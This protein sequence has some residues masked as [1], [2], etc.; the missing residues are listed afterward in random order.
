MKKK[1]ILAIIIILIIFIAKG[2]GEKPKVSDPVFNYK[3]T[4]IDKEVKI[5]IN[6]KTEGAD[7]YYTTDPNEE[8]NVLC[9]QFKEGDSIPLEYDQEMTIRAFAIKKG[10]EDS[11]K[12]TKKYIS[13]RRVKKPKIRII[14][15]GGKPTLSFE[16]DYSSDVYYTLDGEKPTKNNA[17]KYKE[18]VKLK[19]TAIIKAFAV[20]NDYWD[21]EIVT[22][23]VEMKLDNPKF[24]IK[25]NGKNNI[26]ELISENKND[27]IYY[28]L[29]GKK[30]TKNNAKKYKDGIK[31]DKTT[32]IKAVSMKDEYINSDIVEKNIKLKLVPPTININTYGDYRRIKLI[33]NN[34][35]D[36]IYYTL[37]G[38][39]PD[40]ES[41]EYKNTINLKESTIFKARAIKDNYLDSE[42]VSKEI[43]ILKTNHSSKNKSIPKLAINLSNQNSIEGKKIINVEN[44]NKVILAAEEN[45]AN[46]SKNINLYK[47]TKKGK[48]I[49]N[50]RVF[51]KNKNLIPNT[52]IFDKDKYI[53]LASSKNEVFLITINKKGEV[54]N[55]SKVLTNHLGV[56]LIATKDNNYYIGSIY[57]NSNNPHLSLSKINSNSKKVIWQKKINYK[58]KE[59]IDNLYDIALD[60]DNNILMVGDTNK[61]IDTDIYLVKLNNSGQII[62][63]KTIKGNKIDSAYYIKVNE[64]NDYF[65]AGES[66]SIFSENEKD[67]LGSNIIILK[68]DSKGNIKTKKIIGN[69]KNNYLSSFKITGQKTQNII[70]ATNEKN[71]DDVKSELYWL[72]NN[73]NIIQN[74]E[75]DND[76]KEYI[77][78]IILVKDGLNILSVYWKNKYNTKVFNIIQRGA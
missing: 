61:N 73:L 70:L 29:D 5:K 50:K 63:E 74:K 7:I 26:V 59:R 76:K 15:L 43:N 71:D 42:I 72:D 60:Q 8:L 16:R 4:K 65:I 11:N 35:E 22:K 25:E 38:T 31:I 57:N 64:K 28:T 48:V 46:Y 13:K 66:N 19:E 2:W 53:I 27:E 14:N 51:I 68:L 78:D 17:K 18:R 21:S 49:W 10:F 34:K 9:K 54:L 33:S 67:Q 37:D 20:R 32:T 55:K 75:I 3:N 69:N 40:K 41:K 30:P 62:Y 44:S 36:K 52:L 6:S 23:K 39:V 24:K 77:K 56:D 47:T 45:Q 1:I 58:S 12:V